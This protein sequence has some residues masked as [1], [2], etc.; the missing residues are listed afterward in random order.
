MIPRGGRSNID[1]LAGLRP[2]ADVALEF[3]RRTGERITRGGAQWICRRAERKLRQRLK[4]LLLQAVQ[5][6]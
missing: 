4:A 2:W 1:G 3:E 6:E 5:D